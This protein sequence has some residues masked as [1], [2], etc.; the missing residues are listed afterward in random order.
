MK[1]VLLHNSTLGHLPYPQAL[2]MPNFRPL[3]PIAKSQSDS[4]TN[5]NLVWDADADDAD[6]DEDDD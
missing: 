5:F 6:D 1:L 2:C 3:S 4:Y